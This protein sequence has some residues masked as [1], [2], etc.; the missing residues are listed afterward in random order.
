MTGANSSLLIDDATFLHQ[1]AVSNGLKSIG[2]VGSSASTSNLD[3]IRDMPPVSPNTVDP[4]GGILSAPFDVM[5]SNNAFNSTK[6]V[7]SAVRGSTEIRVLRNANDWIVRMDLQPQESEST[8]LS[9][10]TIASGPESDR[11]VYTRAGSEENPG[12]YEWGIL[13]I[14]R[15]GTRRVEG[16]LSNVITPPVRRAVG[17][18]AYEL[19]DHLGSV[20]GLIEDVST[21][22]GSGRNAELIQSTDYDPFGF[23]R[24]NMSFESERQHRY[25]WQGLRR[26]DGKESAPEYWTPFRM[27]DVRSGRWSSQDPQFVTSQSPY[28]FG[29]QNPISITDEWGL[30]GTITVNGREI[31]VFI[32]IKLYGVNESTTD[33][34]A[35]EEAIEKDWNNGGKGWNFTYGEGGETVYHVTIDVA[36]EYVA[37]AN[38]ALQNDPESAKERSRELKRYSPGVNEVLIVDEPKLSTAHGNERSYVAGGNV[39]VWKGDINVI[40]HEFGHLLG[41]GDRYYILNSW[42]GTSVKPFTGWKGNIMANGNKVQMKNINEFMYSYVLPNIPSLDLIE[43]YGGPRGVLNNDFTIHLLPDIPRS[44]NFFMKDN[45]PYDPPGDAVND[46]LVPPAGGSKGVTSQDPV[47]YPPSK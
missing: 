3:E 29:D 25:S 42:S 6:R 47:T 21:P 35:Y 11:A 17:Y 4:S 19:R 2:D 24:W 28:V 46:I 26:I 22:S 43:G 40:V 18:T 9:F 31:R 10:Y 23:R 8:E 12:I 30:D 15:V 7:K 36:V 44:F 33:A 5:E 37:V 1:S 13:G 27:Y 32:P 16:D 34:A 39:G 20:R 41:L 14:R 45:L 38:A